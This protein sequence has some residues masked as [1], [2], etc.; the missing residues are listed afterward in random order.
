MTGAS[1]IA[2]LALVP[3]MIGPLPLE[4]GSQALVLAICGGGSIE[5]T[6]EKGEGTAPMPATTP[7]CAKGCRSSGKKRNTTSDN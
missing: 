3:A 6:L 2:L 4:Q 5:I 1:F 7:C